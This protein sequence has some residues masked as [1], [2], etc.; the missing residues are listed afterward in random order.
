MVH[1]LQYHNLQPDGTYTVSKEN[2]IYFEVDG[3]YQAIV[4]PASKE[5][6]KKLKKRCSIY[7]DLV[8]MMKHVVT[9]TQ[10]STWTEVWRS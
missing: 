6:G 3:P 5:E 4:L 2:S 1:N 10:C 9:G 7:H 8:T